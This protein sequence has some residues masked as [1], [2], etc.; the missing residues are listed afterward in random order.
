MSASDRRNCLKRTDSVYGKIQKIHFVGIGGIGMSGIAE[1]LINLGYQV[2]GSDLREGETTRRLVSLGGS[3]AYGHRAENLADVDVV[4]TSTAIRQ[5]N[6]EVVEAHR[7]MIPVIP[8]A[9]MLAELMRMK[10]GIAIAGTHGKTTTTSMVA[11]VLSHGGI[12]PT[13]VIGG[14]LDLLGSNA[15]LGQG[16]FLVAEAD[17]S[18][19]SFLKL[20]PTIAVVTNVDEDHLDYYKDLDEIKATFIDFINKVPFYGVAV[21]CLDDPNVQILLPQVKKRLITYGFNSQA[22]LQASDVRHEADR[23]SFAV[24]FGG[25]ELG[26]ISFRMPGRHN[27]LNALAAVAVSM[28]LDLSF[29]EI[30]EGFKDFGGVQRRFQI[31]GEAN[32]IMVVDDYGHH[33]VEVKA[34]LSAARSGWDRRIVAVFQPHRYSRTEALFDDFVTAFNQADVLVLMDIYAASEDPIP[35]VD[36]E[37]LAQGVVEHGHKSCVYTGDAET[38]LKHLQEIVCPGDL[39][40]TLGAGNVWQVGEE[41]LKGITGC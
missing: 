16:K 14:R 19:G 21:L 40:I 13:V 34:T 27:V 35:G 24:H 20:S 22:D 28:E 11:T 26:R 32:D 15:K 9:E 33:P 18:D 25:D 6:P 8:R 38:T 30:A 17:E 37:S 10:Y 2:T 7:R 4:V 31:K 12:D 36:A 3:V 29:A 5:D 1:V 23:T 39:V 41:Y